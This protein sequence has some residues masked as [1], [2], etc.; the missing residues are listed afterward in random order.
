MRCAIGRYAVNLTDALLAADPDVE[1][2]VLA[3]EGARARAEKRL[4]VVPTYRRADD[5]G[6]AVLSAARECGADVA[7]FQ[8]APDL[9]GEDSRLPRVCRRLR[10]AGVRPI[11]TLHTVYGPRRWRVLLG[12]PPTSRFHRALG[13]AVDRLIVQQRESCVTPLVA[14]GLDASRIVVIPHGTLPD[15][16]PDAGAARARLGLAR[17]EVVLTFFGSIWWGKNVGT[18][19]DAFAR[20]AGSEPRAR[21][22]V[23]GE[24]WGRRWYNYAL[25]RRLRARLAAEGVSDRVTWIDEYLSDERARDAIVASDV[26]LLPH[27]QA[28]GSA[29]GVFHD[30]AGA[31]RAVICSR[32]PKF[33]DAMRLLRDIPEAVVPAHDV[34]AWGESMRRMVS[35]ATLRERTRAALVDYAARTSWAEVARR[36]LEVYGRRPAE[37]AS[38]TAA[39]GA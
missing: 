6:D 25:V 27:A 21:L 39:S 32:A 38:R 34:A 13:D 3:E 11:V 20:I 16:D 4:R 5:Y 9:L 19:V 14:Q 17:D 28:Y 8:Y 2:T 18:L 30:A 29:S 15:P 35:D 12:R 31:G 24:A 36:Q 37:V 26:V 23:A 33:E 22:L 7:H 10:A 1:V